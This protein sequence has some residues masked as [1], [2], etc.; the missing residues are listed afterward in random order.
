MKPTALMDCIPPQRR[1][2]NE[3]WIL[4]QCLACEMQMEASP[5]PAIA[6]AKR[7]VPCICGSLDSLRRTHHPLQCQ[8]TH[9][10]P[11]ISALRVAIRRYVACVCEPLDSFFLARSGV[12]PF[13][14]P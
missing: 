2:T 4:A 8:W 14:K 9:T 5:E 1:K 10:Y 3:A 11:A 6:A 13:K 7:T 12:Q